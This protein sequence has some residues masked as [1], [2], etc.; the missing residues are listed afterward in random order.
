MYAVRLICCV[1]ECISDDNIDSNKN[2]AFGGYYELARSNLSE[3]C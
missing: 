1:K 2:E 3:N